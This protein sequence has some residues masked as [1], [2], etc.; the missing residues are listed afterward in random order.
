MKGGGSVPLALTPEQMKG[1]G[2]A[3]LALTP[4]QM[5]GIP[6]DDDIGTPHDIDADKQLNDDID[7]SRD[8]ASTNSVKR[9]EPD[10]TE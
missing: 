4:E 6:L 5:K 8:G 9:R 2:S 7:T 10:A 1:G 3:P